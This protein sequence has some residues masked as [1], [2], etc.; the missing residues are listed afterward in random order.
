MLWTL[1]KYI[2]ILRARAHLLSMDGDQQAACADLQRVIQLNGNWRDYH[3]RG[4]TSGAIGKTM[5]AERTYRIAT[6][7]E[8]CA[9]EVYVN[10]LNCL[11]SK[12]SQ[13]EI[14]KTLLRERIIQPDSFAAN[15]NL[16][17]LLFATKQRKLAR[18]SYR[19][20][21]LVRP[22]NRDALYNLTNTLLESGETQLALKVY[23]GLIYGGKQHPPARVNHANPL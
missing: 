21:A 13:P 20:A 6:V 18:H 23:R 2:S 3:A 15:Y 8:P 5:L 17:N 4:H 9:A 12:Q 11:V 22:N 7:L 19:K 16:G 14:G 10:L 1:P